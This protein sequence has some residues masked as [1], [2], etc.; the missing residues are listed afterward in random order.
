MMG[1]SAD[2][3]SGLRVTQVHEGKARSLLDPIFHKLPAAQFPVPTAA[4]AVCLA[5]FYVGR[6]KQWIHASWRAIFYG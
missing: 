5:Y 1:L 2:I 4:L 3:S 6:A